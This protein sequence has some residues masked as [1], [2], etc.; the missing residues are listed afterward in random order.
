MKNNSW[1]DIFKSESTVIPGLL[2]VYDAVIGNVPGLGTVESMAEKFIFPYNT[3]YYGINKLIK[4][5]CLK[6]ASTAFVCNFGG[7]ATSLFTVPFDLG[8]SMRTA[9][10]IAHIYGR[11]IHARDV[12]SL[13]LLSLCGEA[14]K[15]ILRETGRKLGQELTKKALAH[16][17]GDTLRAIN[18]AVGF[19]LFTKF[20]HTGLINLGR[21]VPVAGGF[22][23]SVFSGAGTLATGKAAKLIFEK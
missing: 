23:A 14:S 18:K 11:N 21:L 19:R 9:A 13:C 15:E 7:F 20:G 6:A 5:Q 4:S 22:V 2:A 17:S 8:Q 3:H 12:K 10:A 1:K 16:I